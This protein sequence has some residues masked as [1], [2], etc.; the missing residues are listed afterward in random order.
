MRAVPARLLKP[1]SLHLC[2]RRAKAITGGRSRAQECTHHVQVLELGNTGPPVHDPVDVGIHD[3]VKRQ[4][5]KQEDDDGRSWRRVNAISLHNK[6]EATID[7]MLS[8]HA[9]RNLG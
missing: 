5:C 9:T 4:E 2:V 8:R 6:Q 3:K 7:G 1:D